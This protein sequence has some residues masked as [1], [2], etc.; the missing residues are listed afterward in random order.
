VLLLDEKWGQG[1]ARQGKAIE[2]STAEQEP[3]NRKTIAPAS[4]GWLATNKETNNELF[5]STRAQH[6]KVEV[7]FWLT[8]LA[9]CPMESAC[10]RHESAL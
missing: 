6:F 9:R 3:N 10:I 7:S 8:C 5:C 1:K 2:E 4:K